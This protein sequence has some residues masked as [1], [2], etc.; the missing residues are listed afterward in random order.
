MNSTNSHISDQQIGE[1]LR[2]AR[3]AASFTQAA[4][5]IVINA[6]RTTIVAIEKGQR[7][8]RPE[9]LQKLA[10]AYKTS[11]NAILRCEAVQLDLIP[12]FRKLSQSA[13]KSVV[14]A[15][16]L[17]ND[18]VRAE[19]ELE[20]ALGVQRP[21]NYP[22]ERPLLPGDVKVQAEHDAQELRDWLG[23]GTGSIGD[24]LSILDLQMGIRV[25]IRQIDSKVSGLYAFDETAGACMLLN[26][27][28]PHERF[29]QTVVHELAHFVSTRQQTEALTENERY[30]SREE[31]YAACYARC[32]L[33]PDRALRRQFAQVTAGQSHLTRR[34]VILL[35][36]FF[37]VS[38]EAM[39]RRLEELKLAR[40]GTWDWFLANGGITDEQARQV[41]G[42]LNDRWGHRI[43]AQGLVPPR[44]ALLTREAW[45][46]GI[47]SEGQL[48]RLLRL[49]RRCIREIL[50]GADREEEEANDLFKLPQ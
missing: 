29:L 34:H 48:A 19:V 36:Q 3:E 12:R 42:Y 15:G 21:R 44:L 46:Q 32:F 47:Y 24:L 30:A 1:R 16:Q 28:H 8:V 27:N 5:A 50:D 6:A 13:D 7:R 37:G 11:A 25:Y 23:L 20:N 2:L 10:F 35:A 26:A 31:R 39:A 22:P 40:L 9:E 17:L 41:L 43:E 49:D 4:A 18:L 45:K 33:I 14:D 38:R